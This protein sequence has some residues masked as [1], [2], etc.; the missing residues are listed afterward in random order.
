M[1][2]IVSALVLLQPVPH[3]EKDARQD[4]GSNH[5]QVKLLK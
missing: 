1:S 4:Q 5:P 3:L 2:V